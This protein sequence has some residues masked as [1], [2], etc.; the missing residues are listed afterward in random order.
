MSED[1]SELLVRARALCSAQYPRERD[2]IV[3]MSTLPAAASVQEQ[4]GGVTVLWE[5]LRGALAPELF[6]RC[7]RRAAARAVLGTRWD[8]L[9]RDVDELG[10]LRRWPS[11]EPSRV[12]AM[13]WLSERLRSDVEYHE[14][15]ISALLSEW[16]TFDDPALLRREM[17]DRGWVDRSRDGRRYWVG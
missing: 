1:I 4:R 6:E 11:R 10:R 14:R 16:H 7:A 5:Y 12:A 15:E 13:S 8:L 2:L 3:L 17:Y 9:E